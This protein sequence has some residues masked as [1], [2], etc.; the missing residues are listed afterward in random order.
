MLRAVGLTKRFQTPDGQSLEVLRAADIWL[1]SGGFVGILGRSG[2]GKST[3][4]SLLGGLDRGDGGEIWFDDERLSGASRRTLAQFRG[5][6][7]GFVF[8]GYNLI[9]DLSAWENV[10]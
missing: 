2:S 7:L 6:H 10:L 9:P 1:G 5:R 4:L 3:L 8:Q